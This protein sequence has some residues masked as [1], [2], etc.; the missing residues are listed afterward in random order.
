MPE[1]TIIKSIKLPNGDVKTI[2][3]NVASHYLGKVS[4]VPTT[5]TVPIGP[6]NVPAVEQDWVIYSGSDGIAGYI[7]T[8]STW[9]QMSSIPGD[10]TITIKKNSTKVDDFTLNS[11]TDKDID[12]SV[13]VEKVQVNGSDITPTGTTWNISAIPASIVTAGTFAAGMSANAPTADAHI[14]TK[15]YVD[16]SVQ[17]ITSAMVFKGG[18]TASTASTTTTLTIAD[19]DITT[20]EKGHTFKFTANET[21]GKT[22]KTGDIIIYTSDTAAT[23]SS[24]TLTYD[25]SEWTLVP[26]GDDVDVKAVGASGVGIK[27]NLAGNADI[28]STGEIS[29]KLESDTPFGSS[30]NTYNV[31]VKSNEN[32]GVKIDA[33]S[34]ADV[35]GATSSDTGAKVISAYTLKQLL[36]DKQNSVTP[37]DELSFGTGAAA[38]TLN[39]DKKLGDSA[40]FLTPVLKKVAVNDYGHVTA[41]DDVSHGNIVPAKSK[42]GVYTKVNTAIPGATAPSGETLALFT[43]DSTNECL[44]LNQVAQATETLAEVDTA[45]DVVKY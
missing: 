2:R 9:E 29:L 41:V 17:G 25:T 27:T 23:V 26:S 3:D 38:D 8:G 7:Y 33:L 11:T 24:H 6:D 12:I 35:T 18:V 43:Y 1:S 21:G 19:T 32:L 45:V 36:D 30:D 14:A 39:H 13:P 42:S 20:I 15:K 4:V 10:A 28:T 44:V 40:G 34:K 37:G 5:S 22:F 31:G 16:D